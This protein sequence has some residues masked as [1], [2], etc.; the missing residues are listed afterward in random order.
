MTSL[1][2]R[3]DSVEMRVLADAVINVCA[4][5]DISQTKLADILGLSQASIS[6]LKSGDGSFEMPPKAAEL[7]LLLV[8]I[9]QS[10]D[11]ILANH[12]YEKQWFS[13][14]NTALQ[15]KPSDLVLTAEG[16]VR[17][18]SYLDANRSGL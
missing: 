4:E 6:R 18:V 16:M 8:R 12:L 3:Q 7:A 2:T 11:S 9:Y 10:L 15:A 1:L 5:L 13:S 17:V 14:Y